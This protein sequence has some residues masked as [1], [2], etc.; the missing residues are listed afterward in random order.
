MP[1]APKHV[2]AKDITDRKSPKENPIAKGLS[3]TVSVPETIEIRMVDVSALDDYEMWVLLSTIVI[4][5]AVGFTVAFVQEPSKLYLLAVA[6]L[7]FLLFVC[8]L[9]FALYKRARLRRKSKRV[10][11]KVSEVVEDEIDSD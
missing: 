3:V 7:A 6:I 8:C 5:F 11:M 4:S 2:D 10:Q 1:T 9:S